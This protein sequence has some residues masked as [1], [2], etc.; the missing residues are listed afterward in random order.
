[1]YG[2]RRQVRC[3]TATVDQIQGPFVG[4]S[5]RARFRDFDQHTLAISQSERP[6]PIAAEISGGAL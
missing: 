3:P 6:L 1:M 4:S 5:L 2:D